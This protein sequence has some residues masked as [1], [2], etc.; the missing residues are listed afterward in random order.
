[1]R[2]IEELINKSEPGWEL[3][4]KWTEAAKNKME[5]LPADSVKSKD[6]LFKTQVTTRSP[7][8]AII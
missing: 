2:P 4:K 7:M 3:G 5:I 6:E 1:M 8:G